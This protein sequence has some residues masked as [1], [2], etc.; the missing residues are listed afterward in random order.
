MPQRRARIRSSSRPK[1]APSWAARRVERARPR[2]MASDRGC[3]EGRRVR[4]SA[5]PRDSSRGQPP[6]AP[7]RLDD[8]SA[9][10]GTAGRASRDRLARAPRSQRREAARECRPT[11]GAGL[12]SALGARG[13]R[14]PP[15]IRGAPPAWPAGWA[16]TSWSGSSGSTAPGRHVSAM[17]WTRGRPRDTGERV[18]A[19]TSATSRR[20]RPRGARAPRRSCR[21]RSPAASPASR[22][23]CARCRR[24]RLDLL[25]RLEADAERRRRARVAGRAALG[26]DRLDLLERDGPRDVAAGLLGL[27]PERERD[28]SDRGDRRDPPRARPACQRLKKTRTSAVSTAI[29][30]KTSQASSAE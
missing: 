5:P 22:P 24:P 7:G 10:R 9:G 23:P 13:V 27:E 30:T 6:P 15:P 21:S 19:A 18:H 25:A 12:V 28:D 20:P 3:L 29:A 8:P 11:S 16:R 17:P 1:P 2:P 14:R 26:D 4:S